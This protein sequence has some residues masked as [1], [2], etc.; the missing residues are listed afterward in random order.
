MT[1]FGFSEIDPWPNPWSPPLQI[2]PWSYMSFSYLYEWRLTIWWWF[3][4]FIFDFFYNNCPCFLENWDSGSEVFNHP[5]LR[6]GQG[7]ILG[8]E[9]KGA[10]GLV[11]FLWNE[12]CEK[13]ERNYKNFHL[14]K[15]CH[16]Q[17]R[18]KVSF[19]F[20]WDFWDLYHHKTPFGQYGQS[21][22]G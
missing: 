20:L 22:G 2:D 15:K 14:K 5:F 10:D 11:Q 8:G 4:N 6:G 12:V 17:N 13:H 19:S 7:C 21:G 3:L 18:I 16:I 1:H 9:G